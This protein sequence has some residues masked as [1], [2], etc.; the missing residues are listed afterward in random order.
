MI[1]GDL[2]F[3]KDGKK[4]TVMG[5]AGSLVE[6]CKNVDYIIRKKTSLI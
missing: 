3:Y 4:S 6:D 2:L 5:L 1:F